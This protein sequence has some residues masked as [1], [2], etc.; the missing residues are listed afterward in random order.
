MRSRPKTFTASTAQAMSSSTT[1]TSSHT[2]AVAKLKRLF[3]PNLPATTR[4]TTAQAS[5]ASRRRSSGGGAASPVAAPPV[6]PS[7][8]PNMVSRTPKGGRP[9]LREA[10]AGFR[11]HEPAGVRQDTGGRGDA[12]ASAPGAA[13]SRRQGLTAPS[14]TEGRSGRRTRDSWC[15]KGRACSVRL[16]WFCASSAA[17]AAT[18]SISSSSTTWCWRRQSASSSTC[19]S[20]SRARCHQPRA[21]DGPL[22]HRRAPRER[23]DVQLQRRPRREQ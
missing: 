10:T 2:P 3:E 1:T 17:T 22:P 5:F 12:S 16:K 21:V 6:R 18:S 13:R 4:G 9:R 8:R 11:S 23:N 14:A 19:F 7:R 20:A 15:A